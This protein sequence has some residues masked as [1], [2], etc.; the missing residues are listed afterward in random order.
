MT[1]VT[2]PR[3]TVA[4]APVRA[5]RMVE[6]VNPATGEVFA[7]AP[8]CSPA[9]LDAAFT[10]AAAVAQTWGR[11]EDRRRAL[12]L[13][14]AEAIAAAGDELCEL[15]VLETGKPSWLPPVEVEAAVAWLKYYAA[16]EVPRTLVSDDEAARI[17][18][19]H[20][21]VGVVAGI[22]PW[23][24]PIGSAAWKVA[25]AIRMGCPIVVKPSPFAPLAVLR[26]GEIL[27][28][29]LP[30][31]AVSV[32][33][34]DDALGAAMTRHPVPRKITFTGSIAA[35]KQVALAAAPD[36]KRLTL[37]LGGND[38]AIVLDDVDLSAAAPALLAVATFNTGQTCAIPKRVYVPESLYEDAVEALASAAGE[39][40]HGAGA[41]GQMGPLSTR[42]QFERVST[43]VTD[44]VADGAQA[45]TGG[46]PVDGPGYFYPPTV[47]AGVRDGHR[48]VEEEQFGPIVPVLSY[49]SIDEAVE[50]ANATMYGLCGSVWGADVERA[51]GVAERLECGVTYVNA[52]AALPPQMPFLG[53]KWSGVGV[54]NGVDGLLE[55]AERQVVYTAR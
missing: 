31:G 39:I 49:R 29:H 4:G 5:E 16:A 45:R 23:N 21:P 36:L 52:H 13:E 32:V 20:R 50:R 17:E 35:G 2:V 24:F 41:D 43:L 26:L 34:G 53:T 42:P 19:R 55:F 25:P 30:A 8:A 6:V 54:E 47:L 1:S 18:L 38:A 27:C 33:S 22:I 51:T 28:E 48:V 44:A 12:M 46:A 9:Q 10:G 40:T 3:M 15:L 7:E 37:E 11:D 14:V